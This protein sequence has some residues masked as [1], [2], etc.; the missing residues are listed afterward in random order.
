M[1]LVAIL[2]ALTLEQWRTFEWRASVEHAFVAY[3]RGLEQRLNGGTLGQGI[4]ATILALLN[5]QYPPQQETPVFGCP[6]FA[7]NDR[8]LA[9]AEASGDALTAN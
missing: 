2:V 7:A 3:V 8:Q 9:K 6:L 5:H 4:V 1:N